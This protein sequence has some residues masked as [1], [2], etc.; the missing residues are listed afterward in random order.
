MGFVFESVNCRNGQDAVP[1]FGIGTHLSAMILLKS[2]VSGLSAVDEL[3]SSIPVDPASIVGVEPCDEDSLF[4]DD[5]GVAN[6]SLFMAR[7]SL[8]RYIFVPLL[9][10]V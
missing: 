10:N 2:E 9:G 1:P 7:V 8:R 5:D 4:V 3:G 6:A